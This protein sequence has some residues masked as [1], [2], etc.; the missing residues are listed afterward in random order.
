MAIFTPTSV[1]AFVRVLCFYFINPKRE[2]LKNN[3]TKKITS[4]RRRRRERK[5]TLNKKRNQLL[6]LYLNQTKR[7]DGGWKIFSKIKKN[8]NRKQK[9]RLTKI[10]DQTLVVNKKFGLFI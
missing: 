8:K 9:D 10:R 6:L 3:N 7:D 2:S 4:A 5:Q 1:C